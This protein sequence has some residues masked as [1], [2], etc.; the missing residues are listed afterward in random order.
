MSEWKDIKIA[1]HDEWIFVQD[2]SG[3]SFPACWRDDLDQPGFCNY[4]NC[5]TIIKNLVYWKEIKPY[6]GE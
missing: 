3:N 2:E 5:R 1:P 6:N 4:E